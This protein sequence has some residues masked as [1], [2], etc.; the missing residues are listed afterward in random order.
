[1][2]AFLVAY[3]LYD[4]AAFTPGERK[5]PRIVVA[6]NIVTLTA[7]EKA[8]ALARI[9]KQFRDGE[10]PEH[11]YLDKRQEIEGR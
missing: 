3:L 11:V 6:S 8:R 10:M 7:Q 2:C 1:M 4:P 9:E 5:P